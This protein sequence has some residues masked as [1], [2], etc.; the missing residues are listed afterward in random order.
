MRKVL[1]RGVAG[2]PWDW[3][4]GVGTLFNPALHCVADAAQKQNGARAF[5]RLLPPHR[6]H[7]FQQRTPRVVIAA[8][9]AFAR[10]AAFF[11]LI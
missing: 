2:G 5:D 8:S 10:W 7:Y 3:L 1:A 4:C 6:L 11:T 9:A